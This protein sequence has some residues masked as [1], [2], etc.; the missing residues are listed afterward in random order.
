[1]AAK[2]IDGARVLKV[3]LTPEEKRSIVSEARRN[4]LTIAAYIR[5]AMEAVRSQ[6]LAP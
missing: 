4:G 3:K 1:M 5:H 6:S 2:I